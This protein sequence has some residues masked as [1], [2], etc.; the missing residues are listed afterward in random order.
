[1]K[2]KPQQGQQEKYI[3]CKSDIAIYVGAAVGGNLCCITRSYQLHTNKKIGVV[4]SEGFNIFNRTKYTK[5]KIK[6]R[7]P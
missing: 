6:L 2:I 3:N 7:F 5:L 1:M 4:T